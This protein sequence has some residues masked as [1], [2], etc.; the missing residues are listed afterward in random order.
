MIVTYTLFVVMT[1]AD[2]QIESA[3]PIGGSKTKHPRLSMFRNDITADENEE[4][5]EKDY[6]NEPNN[7]AELM[8]IALE[9]H[10]HA[11]DELDAFAKVL[12]YLNEVKRNQL[13]EEGV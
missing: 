11:T 10:V 5:W 9:I 2:W 1:D 7:P 6:S 8:G 4:L 13:Q 12:T 3:E